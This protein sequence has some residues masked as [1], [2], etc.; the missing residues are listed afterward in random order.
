MGFWFLTTSFGHVVAGNLGS[1]KRMK[2][3]VIGNTVNVAAHLE[4]LNKELHSD[5]L[6]SRDVYTML[7]DDLAKEMLK[8]GDY[9]VKGREQAITVYSV[10]KPRPKLSLL[11]GNAS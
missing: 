11:S 1:D 9:R 8:Q 10:E 5:I 7:P 2:Y 6:L 4:T 3:S